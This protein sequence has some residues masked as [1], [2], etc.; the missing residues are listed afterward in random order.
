MLRFLR[1]FLNCVN[2]AT[3]NVNIFVKMQQ[4]QP[5]TNNILYLYQTEV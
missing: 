3:N 4:K 5:E 2:T 1:N